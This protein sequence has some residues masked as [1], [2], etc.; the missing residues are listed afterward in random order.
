VL[1]WWRAY[2]RLLLPPV[3]AAY[4]DHGVV[5]EPHLQNVLVCAG[6]DG[7]PAAVLIRDL[8]GAKLLRTHHAAALDA[9]PPE[10]AG[11]L[12][13]GAEQGWTRLAYCLLVNNVGDMLAALAD[14]CPAAEPA[15]W[16]AVRDVL[17]GYA[18]EHGG[19][20]RIAALLA[21]AP[22]PAKA[23]LLARWHR[24]ADRQA[25]Y[26]PLPSPL[27]PGAVPGSS[28]AGTA[29]ARTRPSAPDQDGAR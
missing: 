19:H 12:T 1:R 26:V 23:N 4:T 17:A 28:P 13:Y 2:L 8:E 7:L 3:L 24:A 21:G 10:V 18:A 15:L 5:L 22:L 11:P 20:P 29:P 6:G 14:A 16:S 9:L 25:R 27:A